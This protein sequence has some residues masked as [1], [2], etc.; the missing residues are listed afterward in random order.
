MNMAL[1]YMFPV[2]DAKG[3]QTDLT[4]FIP[5]DFIDSKPISKENQR[6]MWMDIIEKMYSRN[7]ATYNKM[8]EI[9]NEL[10]KMK[11]SSEEEKILLREKFH[12]LEEEQ[13]SIDNLIRKLQNWLIQEEKSS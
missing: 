6:K 5:K 9:G 7:R 13:I 12:L 3:K 8:T 4:V 11:D 2:L 10:M 1:S